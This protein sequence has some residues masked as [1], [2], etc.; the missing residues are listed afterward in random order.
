MTDAAMIQNRALRD[1]LRWL[2]GAS[3]GATTLELD[4]VTAAVIPATP[5]RSI[6]N[7]VIYKDARTLESA[8]EALSEVYER[9]G[10][11]AW[12]VW[13]P[14]HD[15]DAIELLRGRG[16]AFDGEPMA[17]TLDLSEF[18]PLE[19]GDLEWDREARFD[20]LGA[21]NDEA[22]GLLG[23]EGMAPALAG[24]AQGSM[25]QLYRALRDGQVACV[26][27]TMDH[28]DDLGIYFVATPQR[29]QRQ[30]LAGRLLAAAL[31]DARERGLR[32]SSLQASGKGEPLYRRLGYRPHFRLQLYERRL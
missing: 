29:H 3:E 28:E 9:A 10:I 31:L 2:G 13:T 19:L 4:G 6:V 5:K 18:A 22:Y 30:G 23:A 8:Y 24:A 14:E 7:S 17:M 21:L 26:L 12:T 25:L 27:A 32:T 16:H 20:E 15:A 11:E 1:F